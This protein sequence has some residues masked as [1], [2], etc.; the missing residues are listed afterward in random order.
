VFEWPKKDHWVTGTGGQFYLSPS[1]LRR[2]A[3]RMR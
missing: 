3:A 2:Y 1:P